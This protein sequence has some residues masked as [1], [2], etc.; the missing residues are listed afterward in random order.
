M[1]Y[2]LQLAQRKRDLLAEEPAVTE[3][4]MFGGLAFLIDGRMAV[5][6]SH[7]GG[8]MIRVDP[9]AVAELV[10]RTNARPIEM[11]GRVM[12]GWLHVSAIGSPDQAR[13]RSLCRCGKSATHGR[14]QR[15]N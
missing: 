14:C 6:V 5:T 7:R 13:A 8:L 12:P 9:A 3:K 11:R 1:A 10:T 2:D 4:R 15:A